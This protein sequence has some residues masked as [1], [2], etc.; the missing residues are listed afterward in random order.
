MIQSQDSSPVNLVPEAQGWDFIKQ[1]EDLIDQHNRDHFEIGM[2]LMTIR[3]NSLY[4][5]AGFENFELYLQSIKSKYDYERRSLYNF[6]RL[7]KYF[8]Q[9]LHMEPKELAGAPYTRLLEI[10]KHFKT[11]PVEEIKEMVLSQ[12]DMPPYLFNQMKK[13]MGIVDT[14]PRMFTTPDGKWTIE[15]Y[16]STIH[17]I[18]NLEDNTDIYHDVP[19][20]SQETKD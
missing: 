10:E 4:K 17:R 7:H 14:K 12:K 15:V 16:K 5:L 19:E 8:V 20:A 9:E 1:T 3:D 11:K 2:R 6:M 13:E 18:T